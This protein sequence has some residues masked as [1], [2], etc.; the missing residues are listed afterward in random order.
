MIRLSKGPIEIDSY[1]SQIA[2]SLTERTHGRLQ[3]AFGST[4]ISHGEHGPTI[5]VDQLTV[6]NAGETIIAAPHAE[7]SL[8]ILSALEFRPRARRLEIYDV[9][10]QLYVLPDGSFAISATGEPLAPAPAP[11]NADS[12]PAAAEPLP[13][14]EAQSTK[15]PEPVPQALVLRHAA[16]GLRRFF[17]LA[18]S[19]AS[20]LAAVRELAIHRGKLSIVD[21]AAERSQVFSDVEINLGRYGVATRLSASAQAANGPI[22]MSA[23]ARGAASEPRLL[24]VEWKDL[25][26][27]EMTLAAGI[28]KP[29]FDSDAKLSFDIRYALEPNGALSEASGRFALTPGY[30]RLE[31]P[32][33]EPFF[34][35]TL[36]GGL[37]WDGAGRRI[38]IDPLRYVYG[39]S[40]LALGGTVEPPPE[41]GGGWRIAI[42]NA[43]PGMLA[44][45]R[46]GEKNLAIAKVAI[47]GVLQPLER[48]VDFQR[49]EMSGPELALSAAGAVDWVYGP[50]VRMQVNVE[51]TPLKA[52]LRVWPSHMGAPARSW[53]LARAR[54][55]VIQSGTLSI[56]FDRNALLMMR[57][58]MPPPD[59][60][61]KIDFKI[62][63]GA[64]S[65][66][67]G[68]ADVRGVNGSGHVTGRT[69]AF[70]ASSAFM[71]TPE[72][73]RIAISS[74]SYAMP[75]N[76]GKPAVPAHLD[77]RV[78]G[79]VDAVA[80]V[81]DSDP[82]R[83]YA[84]L[85][86]DAG[87]L[88]GQIEGR[89][90]LDFKVGVA[91][92]PDDTKVF[93]NATVANFTADKLLGDNK[94]EAPSLSV[95]TDPSGIRA[96]G[97]GKLFGAP[98]TL[99]LRKS[100]QAPATAVVALTLDDA[101]RKRAGFDVPGLSGPVLAKVS[102]TMDG[103]APR[104][105]ID[106]DL[107]RASL[108]AVAPGVA[109]AAGKPG[110]ASFVT[111]SHGKNLTLDNFVYE[112]G[113]VS[114]KGNV[115]LKDGD[116]AAAHFTQAR[117]SPG[118]EMRIDVQ[119]TGDGL[120]AVVRGG[121]IDA[122]PFL[123]SATQTGDARSK[124]DSA[125]DLEVKSPV[126][127][128]FNKRSLTNADLK[129]TTRA[130]VIRA[131][132][133]SGQFPDG[134]VTASMARGYANKPQID[135][136]SSDA[137]ALLAF[138]DLYARMEG[139]ALTASMQ[140][141]GKSVAGSLRINKF[142]LVNEPSLR[143]LV[144]EGEQRVDKNGAV[145][146]DPNTV[147]FDR[148][149]VLFSRTGGKLTL[150]DGVMNG[151]NIGLT[152]DGVVDSVNDTM[153]LRGTFV[154]AYTVNNFFSKIPVVGVLL[155]GGWN[156]GLFAIDYRISGRAAAPVLNI[157]PLSVAPG[158]LRKL[159]GA[160]DA[161]P[162]APGG[163]GSG[164]GG[165]TS[166]NPAGAQ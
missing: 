1:G 107:A 138:A 72:S 110:R 84:S 42:A 31:E 78:S 48:R 113:G 122:R 141:E 146:F 98:A 26:I 49:I 121:S 80:E 57:Y 142:A 119:K 4:A 50:H 153:N 34:F 165:A 106:L 92:K 69:A 33:H 112:S 105:T 140:L 148:L 76:D 59:S 123:K 17:D 35:D 9:A 19:D 18:N 159:F 13:P 47:E 70:N 100:G 94:F 29:K 41:G 15:P 14:D 95:V 28:R 25:S 67:P 86:A 40:H 137:G 131:L 7:L 64:I 144:V 166:A 108:A 81:L 89:L 71:E 61:L 163:N 45:E 93:V 161:N 20:P 2:Q 134:K 133:L 135:I 27:D 52:M 36:S 160:F 162:G 130:G 46:L 10:A 11:A 124:D 44:A 74:A 75:Q 111:V 58:D 38:V 5:T 145:R 37:H 8:D 62:A 85:P 54:G 60:T 88:K 126:I 152:V 132:S 120:K 73:R 129:M 154:P 157:N 125:L 151:P 66:M 56:N 77:A 117:L 55:G 90:Q 103:K 102:A 99:D 118:D 116:F 24:T 39:E 22:S 79:S 156:E 96:S 87:S 82:I 143:R 3:F 23:E 127:S 115:E 136:V 97:V 101:A 68:L 43:E 147:H 158:F 53:F 63:D 114:A 149:Q 91:A 164:G 51:Q 6:K 30:F 155:G 65:P 32:E 21:Q 12:P 128:G 139:G 104:A 83:A 150:R 109:K 16:S